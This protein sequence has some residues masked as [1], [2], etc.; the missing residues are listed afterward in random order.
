[1]LVSGWQQAVTVLLAV[2]PGFLYQ[3]LRARLRGPTPDDRELGVRVVRALAWS[4]AL[5]LLY[6]GVL[7]S[8]LTD[9]LSR[10]A[11]SL[12][13]PRSAAWVAFVLVVVL[14][15]TLA[16]AVHAWT[17]WRAYPSM[18]WSER[19]R[20]YDPTPTA[21][22]FASSRSGPG[23]VR[24]LTKDGAWVGGYAGADS[25]L[26]SY[27]EPR[28]VYLQEAWQMADD[29]TFEA[30]VVGNGT[31]GVWVRCDDVQLVQFLAD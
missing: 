14:P 16:V 19:F 4:G 29:G 18:S 10:P 26:T 3:G 11:S 23:F 30:P 13:H 24:I 17:T 22:D 21:W 1:M 6:V 12:E 15:A 9:A 8:T 5:A 31:V 7:G 28:E 2:V 20:V 25:F 27:P